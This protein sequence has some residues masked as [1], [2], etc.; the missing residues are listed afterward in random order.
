MWF[1]RNFEEEELIWGYSTNSGGFVTNLRGKSLEYRFKHTIFLPKFIEKS[2]LPFL[3]KF[4]SK[5]S[6]KTEAI[7]VPLHIAL[8]G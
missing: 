1:V 2:A 7:G 6:T 8:S 3:L 5:C 4:L